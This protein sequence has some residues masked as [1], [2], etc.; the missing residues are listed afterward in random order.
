M[1]RDACGRTIEYL[2]VS[3]TDRCNLR[4]TYCLPEEGVP[5]LGH[6]DV[7]RFEE[8]A[9]LLEVAVAEGVRSVR[10]TGGEPLLK[11]GILE[12]VR[13]LAALPGLDDLSLTTNGILLPALAR[14]LREAGLRRV[15]LGIP[16]LDPELHARLTRGTPALAGQALA[17][18]HAALAAG[19]S[20]VKVNVVVLRGQNDDLAPFIEL[21]RRLPVDVRFIEYMP[22]GPARHDQRFVPASEILA[23]LRRLAAEGA[24]GLADA[25]APRGAG[26]ARRYYRLAGA[27]GRLAVLA[28][29]SEH[30][31]AG[32]N[33][34]RLSSDGWLR[35]C[36]FSDDEIDM[37]AALRPRPDPEMLRAL[38]LRAVERKPAALPPQPGRGR[39]LMGQIGG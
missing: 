3:V 26:P 11:R 28:P 38:L 4:C 9:A 25:E 27:A 35:L 37:K 34:L 39:R 6:D 19:L 13:R 8:L 33:R 20:P 7:L 23:R 31:C 14:P 21:T 16:S 29:V 24:D 36:L 18:L 32:C 17:G 1:L 10:L 12:L 5:L 22:I 30:F 15:N 2:R